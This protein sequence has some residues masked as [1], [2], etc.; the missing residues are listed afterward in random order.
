MILVVVAV[1]L[2][3]VTVA[4]LL[5]KVPRQVFLLWSLV[6]GLLI[7]GIVAWLFLLKPGG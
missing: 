7:F 1:T 2:S 6:E 3:M 5:L 4:M